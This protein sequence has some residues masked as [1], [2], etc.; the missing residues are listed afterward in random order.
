MLVGWMVVYIISY[1]VYSFFLPVYSFWCMDDFGWGNTR[2]VIGEGKDKKVIMNE[3]EKFDDSMI[4]LKRFSEYEA[5]AWETQ[6]HHTGVSGYHGSRS[7]SRAP[8]SRSQSPGGYA[9]SQSGDYY[10]DTNKLK[11]HGTGGSRLRNQP[12]N[13]NMSQYGQQPMSQFGAP[14][15]LPFMPFA[16]G[17]GSA[18]GSDY[19]GR[20]GMGM[21]IPFQPT[22]G[23]VYG[24][25]MMPQ[26]TGSAYGIPPPGM[27]G[28]GMYGA[29]G[30]GSQSVLGAPNMTRPM[31]TFSM[32]TSV[33]AFAGPSQNVNPTD[34]EL[35]NALR[36]YLSTQD[37]MTVTKK[38]AREA[39]AARF[40]KAD[41]STR[42]DFLNES[43]D[44]ILSQS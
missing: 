1:P 36:I 15:Q 23:S 11:P 43:I 38:T 25:P 20:M 27:M 6:S 4:P 17:P 31:S 13:S 7:P 2:L 3:E 19:G 22:G 9:A 14:P 39:I 35:F 18:A 44:K 26:H 42:K 21:G 32:A 33:N 28:M 37:L 30:D 5:E 40:P 16:G 41:L 12:S 29:G 8:G 24:M 34:D 10:R